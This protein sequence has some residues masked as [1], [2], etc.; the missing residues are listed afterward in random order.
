LI[1]GDATV[2]PTP[3]GRFA[4]VDANSEGTIEIELRAYG[5]CFLGVLGTRYA[6]KILEV[7]D[8]PE[9]CD[10]NESTLLPPIRCQELPELG[11][12][13]EVEYSS[14]MIVPGEFHH[15]TIPYNSANQ[16]TGLRVTWVHS[17]PYVTDEAFTILAGPNDFPVALD[18]TQSELTLSNAFAR[19]NEGSWYPTFHFGPT[20]TVNGATFCTFSR[21]PF[22]SMSTYTVQCADSESFPTT[23]CYEDSGIPLKYLRVVSPETGTDGNDHP[24]DAQDLEINGNAIY[25]HA[26]RPGSG[27]LDFFTFE[28]PAAPAYDQDVGHMLGCAVEVELLDGYLGTVRIFDSAEDAAVDPFNF[29]PPG[30]APKARTTIVMGQRYWVRV[31]TTANPSA[32]PGYRISAVSS[33]TTTPSLLAMPTVDDPSI[34]APGNVQVTLEFTDDTDR[35]DVVLWDINA[36]IARSPVRA[37]LGQ[38]GT[39]TATIDIPVNASAPPSQTYVRVTLRDPTFNLRTTYFLDPNVSTTQ[40]TALREDVVASDTVTE[41]TTFALTQVTIE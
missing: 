25:K 7:I 10:P 5:S 22:I 1:S 6:T 30:G 11:L 13:N 28:A 3:G 21:D 18:G 26:S 16:G 29:P 34:P 40:Y 38:L 2:T 20:I 33:C 37:V 32:P 36:D 12:T 41:L 35:V 23:V 39:G 31:Q 9:G 17:N 8:P 24:R 19:Q 27:N 14:N 15:L 4:V